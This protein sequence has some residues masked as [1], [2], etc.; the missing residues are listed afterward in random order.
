MQTTTATSAAKPQFSNYLFWDS[1]P[2]KIDFQRDASHVIRRVFDIGR[3]DDV[4][5]VM[6]IYPTD[7][8]VKTLLSAHY[9]PENAIYLACALFNLKKEDFKCYNRKEEKDFRDVHALLSVYTLGE[10][11]DFY[12]ERIPGRD[13]RLV[14]DHLAAAAAADRQQPVIL[15]KPAEYE[16]IAADIIRAIQEHLAFLKAEKSRQA[17]ERLRQRLDTLKKEN[18]QP[19]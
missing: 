4:A 2:E 9:L 11:L 1:D 13:L 12:R 6:R 8:I 10:L 16:Q 7:T 3:L 18:D 15:L 17:E 5:E 14:I 19:E